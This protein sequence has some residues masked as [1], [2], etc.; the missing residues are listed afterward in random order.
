MRRSALRQSAVRGVDVPGLVRNEED[1]E[2]VTAQGEDKRCEARK[3]YW[4]ADELVLWP[5]RVVLRWYGPGECV[6]RDLGTTPYALP[7]G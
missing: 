2:G 4:H 1:G 6:V 7:Y 5:N 3:G